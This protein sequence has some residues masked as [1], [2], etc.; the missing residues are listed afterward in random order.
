MKDPDGRIR[1]HHGVFGGLVALLASASVAV[2]PLAD[3]AR[4]FPEARQTVSV[5]AAELHAELHALLDESDRIATLLD[6]DDLRLLTRYA[7]QQLESRRGDEPLVQLDAE[8]LPSLTRMRAYMQELGALFERDAMKRAGPSPTVERDDGSSA[9][10]VGSC[11]NAITEPLL[12]E[13]CDDGNTDE[14]DGCL[15]DCTKLAEGGYSTQCGD[16]RIS[17][18]GLLA[19]IIVRQVVELAAAVAGRACEQTILGFDGSTVCL[20]TDALFLAA[21]VAEEHVFFCEDDVNS[22]EICGSYKRLD[23]IH[24]ALTSARTGT[25]T[26]TSFYS[27]IKTNEAQINRARD[28]ILKELNTGLAAVENEIMDLLDKVRMAINMHFAEQNEELRAWREYIVRLWIEKDLG[29]EMDQH[30][31]GSFELPIAIACANAGPTVPCAGIEDVLEVVLETIDRMVA[32]GQTTDGAAELADMC[33][34]EI[35]NM[36]WKIAYSLCK[37]AYRSATDTGLDVVTTARGGPGRGD[38]GGRRSGR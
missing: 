33:S 18:G 1:F 24:T 9:P 25:F 29:R 26:E 34:Q 30:R 17:P 6:R 5:D 15:S 19:T 37:Q 38:T 23:D 35:A 10:S 12:G 21:V 2:E 8:L 31:M 36:N 28:Q 20:V 27:S 7:R 4:T 3:A 16:N 32:S 11:G 14:E 13:E 22:A